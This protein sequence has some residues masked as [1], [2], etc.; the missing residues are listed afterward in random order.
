[1]GEYILSAIVISAVFAILGSLSYSQSTE[2]RERIAL[3]VLLLYFLVFPLPGIAHGIADFDV[4]IFDG[5]VVLPE[6]GEYELVAREA[7]CEGVREAVSDKYGIKKD[8]IEVGVVG[9]D[10]GKMRAEKIKILLSGVG[11]LADWRSIEKY[12]TELGLGE[13][14]VEIL[15]G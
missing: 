8:G 12:V 1:M 13:C 7:F 9:F 11:A 6:D 3:S 5:Q 14:E 15:I 2:G 4:S 10:F